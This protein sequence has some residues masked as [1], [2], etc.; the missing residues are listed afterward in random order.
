[1]ATLSR[2][3][4]PRLIGVIKQTQTIAKRNSNLF[5]HDTKISY[6]FIITET[7]L[8]IINLF[9]IKTEG[10]RHERKRTHLW[11]TLLL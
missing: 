7:K 6:Q 4:K 11:A 2:G 5:N 3:C 8:V 10:P 1:M 9:L